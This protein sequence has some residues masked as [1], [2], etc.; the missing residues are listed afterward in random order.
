MQIINFDFDTLIIKNSSAS[1]INSLCF[2]FT[3]LFLNDGHW[4][5]AIL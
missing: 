5:A 1:S 4:A 2:E 3:G